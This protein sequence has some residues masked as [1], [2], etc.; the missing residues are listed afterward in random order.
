LLDAYLYKYDLQLINNGQEIA[1]KFGQS[2]V[3][4]E[5][6]SMFEKKHQTRQGLSSQWGPK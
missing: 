4:A 1:G 2:P 5:A 6:L 3:P